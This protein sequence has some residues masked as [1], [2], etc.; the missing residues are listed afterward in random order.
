MRLSGRIGGAA[1]F[2]V[3][4]SL[5]ATLLIGAPAHDVPEQWK[6]PHS[7]R[8]GLMTPSKYE[9]SRRCAQCHQT[10]ARQWETNH[11]TSWKRQTFQYFYNQILQT[12]GKQ[13][14][15][16]CLTCH[17]PISVAEQRYTVETDIEKE[18]VSCDFCHSLVLKELGQFESRPGKV[19]RGPRYP[20]Y[21]ASHGVLY[22][23]TYGT[24]EYCSGCHIWKSSGGVSILDEFTYWGATKEAAEGKQCQTC[25]MPATEGFASDFGG[26]QRPD[27]ASHTFLS[28][29]DT[30]FVKS[31]ITL[32]VNFERDPS[33]PNI[34]KI[35]VEV[36]NSGSAHMFPGGFSW[37]RYDLVLRIRN[38]DGDKI[39][40]AQS[41]TFKRTLADAKGN[42]TLEDWRAHSVISDTRLKPG[43][44]RTLTY[45]VDLSD[46]PT[47]EPYYVSAQIFQI[48]QPPEIFDY[49]GQARKLPTQILSTFVPVR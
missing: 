18:G 27:V 20:A 31:A 9:D 23:R 42:P 34:G 4:V 47:D 32:N 37:R 41:E 26:F 25:H 39:F 48:R 12:T 24:S 13:Y 36:T 21:E 17:A 43:E 10:L 29:Q 46:L 11:A 5:V 15:V 1:L 49:L 7:V 8:G 19:K 2:G 14:E 6:Y 33:N 28:S 22:D 30:D 16:N 40:W 45:T 35:T 38:S 44:K 3:V